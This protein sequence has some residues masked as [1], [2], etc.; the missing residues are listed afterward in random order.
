LSD[1][2][3]AEL[4]DRGE[5]SQLDALDPAKVAIVAGRL[6]AAAIAQLRNTVMHY[7]TGRGSVR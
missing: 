6:L 3:L 1:V 4:I 7:A 2:D 5:I